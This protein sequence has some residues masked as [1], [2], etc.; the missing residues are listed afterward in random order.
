MTTG[1]AKIR[2]GELFY[3]V[4]GEGPPVV[5]LHGGV[6]HSGMW[7]SQFEL[8]ARSGYKAVRY[9]ARGHGSSSTPTE[10]YAL[11]E[12]LHDLLEALGVDHAALVGMSMGGATAI[13][14]ALSY[15]RM[16]EALV[17]VGP[18]IS[19]ME[20]QDPF[21]LECHERQRAAI[22]DRDAAEYVEWFLRYGVDGPYRSPEQV[23]PD[24]RGR[25]REMASETVANH[26][27]AR[28]ALIELAAT[29]RVEELRVPIL[30]MIGELELPDIVGV[31]DLLER[32]ALD[33]KK[34]VFTGAGHMLNL[35]RV[36]EFNRALLEL[37][38]GT[39]RGR[40]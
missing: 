25:C 31:V 4:E 37:L 10:D 18:G 40:R 11:H 27:A 22:E 19:G 14:F 16:V 29:E 12:D 36:E 6:L 30:A 5:L 7:D 9:D 35:E 8:L 38:S 13:D 33:V 1:V 21:V 24:V 26:A 17:L 3:E 34:I 28:G 32:K 39:V 23:D 2:D 15:P 20:F